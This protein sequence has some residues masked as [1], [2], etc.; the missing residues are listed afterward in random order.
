MAEDGSFPWVCS[1]EPAKVV[2]F[3]D[4][5]LQ[6]RCLYAAEMDPDV[7]HSMLCSACVQTADHC[8]VCLLLQGW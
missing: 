5:P 2:P 8:C 6:I 3:A 7:G 1:W 4:L